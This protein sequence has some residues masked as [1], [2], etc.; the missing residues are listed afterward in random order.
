M[1]A[2]TSTTALT[3][4]TM[5]ANPGSVSWTVLDGR[6]EVPD[7]PPVLYCPPA[8]FDCLCN[9]QSKDHHLIDGYGPCM[10]AGCGCDCYEGAPF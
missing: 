4:P 7:E 2:L 3:V 10:V 9:H 5:S 1:T 6:H 8:A